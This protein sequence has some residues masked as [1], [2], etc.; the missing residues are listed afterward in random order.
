MDNPGGKIFTYTHITTKISGSD[1]V[2]ATLSF[3]STLTPL[4]K[5]VRKT[6]V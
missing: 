4:D 1:L 6:S 3:V 5:Y 2:F